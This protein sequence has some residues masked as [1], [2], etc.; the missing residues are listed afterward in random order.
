MLRNLV[1]IVVLLMITLLWISLVAVSNVKQPEH[2]WRTL[3]L[4]TNGKV[5]ASWAQIGYGS[6]VIDDNSLR[7]EC[8]AK[9]MGL[10]L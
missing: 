2:P 7:T 6:M 3:P 9:G 5:D 8:D 10:F 4:I 1:K